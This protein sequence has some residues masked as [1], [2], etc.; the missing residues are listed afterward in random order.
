M[1][2]PIVGHLYQRPITHVTGGALY[3]GSQLLTGL[4]AEKRH[5]V[6]GLPECSDEPEC[7]GAIGEFGGRTYL[8]SDNTWKD[9][10]NNTGTWALI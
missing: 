1:S 5:F 9:T 7:V 6:T 10:N 3:L 2:N 4:G 8:Y